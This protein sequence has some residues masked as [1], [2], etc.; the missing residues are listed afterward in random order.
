MNLKKNDIIKQILLR[1]EQKVE[2][3]ALRSRQVFEKLD[4]TP[5]AKALKPVFFESI[6]KDPTQ[7]VEL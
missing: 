6:D 2:A 4:I 7:P 1:R 5:S 3:K